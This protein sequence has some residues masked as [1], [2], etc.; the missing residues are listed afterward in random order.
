MV[1]RIQFLNNYMTAFK[2]KVYFYIKL[3][4]NLV[5]I[6]Y[7]FKMSDYAKLVPLYINL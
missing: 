6:M 5:T 4:Y 2:K 1:L 3:L 7:Y